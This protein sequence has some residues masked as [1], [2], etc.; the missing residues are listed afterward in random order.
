MWLSN[1]CHKLRHDSVVSEGDAMQAA[2]YFG[3]TNSKNDSLSFIE[4][5]PYP[6]SAFGEL[7]TSESLIRVHVTIEITCELHARTWRFSK[8]HNVCQGRRI[9][10]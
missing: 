2:F 3:I 9:A 6:V 5:H 8:S 4:V 1:Y 7:F 10:R